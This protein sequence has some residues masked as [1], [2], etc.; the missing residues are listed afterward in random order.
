MSTATEIS[1]FDLI[2]IE[3]IKLITCERMGI[4]GVAL[5]FKFAFKV[6]KHHS[7]IFLIGRVV[8]SIAWRWNFLEI[9]KYLAF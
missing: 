6:F 5:L 4:I 7:L 3:R 8:Y 9:W 1:E 2:I